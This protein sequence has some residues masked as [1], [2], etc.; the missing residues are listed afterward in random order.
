MSRL[1]RIKQRNQ[2]IKNKFIELTNKKYKGRV[3]LYTTDTV[4]A[5]LAEE[6]YLAERTIEDIVFSSK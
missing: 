1:T 6:F 2:D 5:M 4:I 3:R